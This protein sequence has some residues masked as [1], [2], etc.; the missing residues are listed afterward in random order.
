MAESDGTTRAERLWLATLLP[1]AETEETRRIVGRRLIAYS[2]I[3][4]LNIAVLQ[5]EF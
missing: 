4:I 2:I 5:K 3:V 1:I